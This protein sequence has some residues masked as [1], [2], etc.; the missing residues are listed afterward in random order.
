MSIAN[1]FQEKKPISSGSNLV[2]QQAVST[3]VQPDVKLDICEQS[4]INKSDTNIDLFI[5]NFFDDVHD[6]KYKP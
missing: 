4:Q 3:N 6:K 5:P 1:I 2:K